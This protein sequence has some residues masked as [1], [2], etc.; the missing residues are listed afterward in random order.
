MTT[1]GRDKIQFESYTDSIG[2]GNEQMH[3]LAAARAW[4]N[5]ATEYLRTHGGGEATLRI[6]GGS[7]TR[8]E[9]TG[10][11]DIADAADDAGWA[12]VDAYVQAVVAQM[13]SLA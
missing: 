3:T 9:V 2:D 6:V 13:D 8:Y 5:A 7:H 11:R 12:A 4:Q 10:D 1:I